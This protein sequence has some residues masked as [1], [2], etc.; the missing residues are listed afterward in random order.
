M[1]HYLSLDKPALPRDH[2]IQRLAQRGLVAPVKP[3][4]A[5]IVSGRRVFV[6]PLH[7]TRNAAGD[8]KGI[9]CEY[10]LDL[11]EGDVIEVNAPV[12][13]AEADRYRARIVNGKLERV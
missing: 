11:E 13:W 2:R 1:L 8:G 10:Y 4:V 12:S 3:W 7:D 9:V 5:R 6:R